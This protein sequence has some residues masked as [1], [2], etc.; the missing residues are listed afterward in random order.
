MPTPTPVRPHLA[1]ALAQAGHV[2]LNFRTVSGVSRPEGLGGRL[3]DLM[4]ERGEN[5]S[6]VAWLLASDDDW[7]AIAVDHGHGRDAFRLFADAEREATA[8][9]P[10]RPHVE[11]FLAACRESGRRVAIAGN[12]DQRVVRAYLKRHGLARHVDRVLCREAELPTHVA[13]LAPALGVAGDTVAAVSDSAVALRHAEAAGLRAI[14]FVGGG[15]RRKHL[16]G[17][18]EVFVTNVGATE[19]RSIPAL[20]R[21][22]RWGEGLLIGR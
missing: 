7:Y 19:T 14:G 21:T 12:Y 4:R 1:A 10:P 22:G 17:P 16:A 8:D 3:H 5:F 9:L 20:W 13:E 18:G 15:D 6:M 11:E 2:L